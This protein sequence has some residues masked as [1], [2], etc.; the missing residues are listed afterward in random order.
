MIKTQEAD[1]P[2]DMDCYTWKLSVELHHHFAVKPPTLSSGPSR[3]R[4]PH[5][6]EFYYPQSMGVPK[7]IPLG[8]MGHDPRYN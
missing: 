3:T 4:W 6:Y 7:C 1:Q 2:S 5:G 8:S